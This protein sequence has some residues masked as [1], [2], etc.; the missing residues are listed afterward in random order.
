MVLLVVLIIVSLTVGDTPQEAIVLII[1]CIPL[2]FLFFEAFF[3]EVVITPRGV[4]IKKFLRKKELQWADITNVGSMI[5][6][7]KVYLLLTSTKGFHILSNAIGDFTALV[8][9]IVE[10]VENT[11]VEGEEGDKVEQGVRELF[12]NPVKRVAD[13]VTTWIAAILLMGVVY[14]KLIH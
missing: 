7:K 5:V 11:R 9:E 4:V 8:A 6:R 1:V 3:R 13:V 12:Q 2:A 14:F 10:R